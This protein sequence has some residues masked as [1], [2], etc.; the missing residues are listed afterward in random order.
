[1]RALVAVLLVLFAIL[2]WAPELYDLMAHPLMRALP[3]GTKMIATGVIAPFL[4]PLKVAGVVAFVVALPYVLYQAWAFVA[5]GLYAH[6]KKLVLPLVIASTVLFLMGIAF[7]YFFVF[8]V[9]FE[10]VY[11]IA[12]K[13]ISVAPDIE[14][15]MSFALSMFIA[16]G[17]TFEVPVV[18]IVLVRSGV[19]TVEKLKEIRPY[20][21]VG[22][23]V[24]GAIFTPPDVV[25]QFMLA[26]PL[27]VLYE[28]GVFIAGFQP[29]RPKIDSDPA[30]S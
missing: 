14:N 17:V 2:P 18:V 24:V 13:S 1:V 10:F 27:W 25:S 30:A 4:V 22:A 16:F 9:V 23:F 29:A 19:V 20:V 6:E 12:P 5:P 3:E 7:C 21:I 15:Y 8:G 26:I 11:T 28:I